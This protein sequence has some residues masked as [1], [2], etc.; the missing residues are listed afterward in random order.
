MINGCFGGKED[1]DFFAVFDGHGG[2]ESAE[3][4]AKNIPM[5]LALNLENGSDVETAITDSIMTV[6][7]D[8]AGWSVYSGTTICAA[9]I[10]QDTLYVANCGDTRA[11]LCRKGKPIRLSVDHNLKLESEKKRILDL[12]GTVQNDRVQG[13][14]AVTRAIGDSMLQPYLTAEPHISKI[15]LTKGDEYL[16]IGCDGLWDVISETKM[17]ELVNEQREDP[18]KAAEKLQKAALEAGSED[19]ISIVAIF[20]K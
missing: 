18:K 19:N 20:F 15:E 14:I 9:L 17:V 3:F 7:K 6:H 12:G 2:K 11:V 5:Q 16:V 4:A 10:I 1:Q 13:M 8:M